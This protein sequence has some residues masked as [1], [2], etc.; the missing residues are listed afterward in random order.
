MHVVTEVD[1]SGALL[2]RNAYNTEFDG[3]M[4]FFDVSGVTRTLTGDRSEFIGRNGSLRAPAAMSRAALGGRVGACLDPCGAIQV[5]LEL[6]DGE[7][8]TVLFRLGAGRNQNEVVATVRRFRESGAARASFD[9]VAALW[10]RLLGAVQVHTPDPALD[11]LV[12]GW[13][14]YQVIACRM[15]GRSGF[16]QSGGAFGFRDQLQDAMA[17]VHAAPELLREHLLLCASRQFHEGDVQHW[18]HPPLGRGV[19]THC[20]DDYLWL[21]LATTRYVR[22]TDDWA[23]LDEEAGFLDGRALNPDEESYYDMPLRSNQRASLYQHCVLAIERGFSLTGARGLPLIGS[24]D[25]NDGMNNVGREGR[26]ES[27]W[28]GFFLHTIATG[29]AVLARRRGDDAFASRCEQG[30]AALARALEEHGWDGHWY[31][32]AWYDDGTPLGSTRSA[33]C[34]IDSIAQ[35]WAVLSGAGDPTRAAMALDALDEHL[36][37][38]EAGL[39]QLLT[40]PFDTAPHDPGY[41]RGYVPGVRENG[42]QYTHAA[43]W[44]VMAF[45]EAGRTERAWELFDL[46]NPLRHGSAGSFRT[47]MVEPYVVAAD[48]LAVP[49]HTGRGG[50]TWYTGAAGWMYRLIVESLLG[51]HRE[52]DAL[53]FAPRLPRAW[54]EA[55]LTYRCGDGGYR[56]TLRHAAAGAASGITLDGSAL[57]GMRL[58]LDPGPGTHEVEVVAAAAT[59]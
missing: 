33:E 53:V 25:W 11:A 15:W 12:N 39:I 31:R 1:A 24:G 20:S 45:A 35:S 23:V 50:W 27:V 57:E 38:P 51:I 2:A 3:Y 34:R 6:A 21:P 30:A 56:I 44:A 5:P 22:A 28:L 40:P 42:G 54:P 58:P 37:H 19:R 18:W 10:Q 29:F 8:R 26:G 49:P 41:I 14:P 46:I 48:V 52:G 32:R 43:I 4:A 17:L 55:R 47:W 16:Y 7:T 9:G 36:V 13:L 59:A